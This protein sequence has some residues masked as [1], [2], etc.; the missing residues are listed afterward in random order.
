MLLATLDFKPATIMDPSTPVFPR[1]VYA[2]HAK[3][4]AD[5]NQAMHDENSDESLAYFRSSI[6]GDVQV[7]S[8]DGVGMIGEELRKCKLIFRSV[9]AKAKLVPVAPDSGHIG[10]VM[11]WREKREMRRR[12]KWK[13]APDARYNL[14]R[15]GRPWNVCAL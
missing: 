8:N 12:G 10:G 11:K 15:S 1:A 4:V 5:S 7:I 14:D 13:V 9:C 6:S 3:T 2:H